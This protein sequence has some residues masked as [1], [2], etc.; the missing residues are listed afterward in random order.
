MPPA[1]TRQLGASP[2]DDGGPRS[3]PIVAILAA[4]VVAEA[5]L[6]ALRAGTALHIAGALLG[7]PQWSSSTC[8]SGA[9]PVG[10]SAA[11]C[12]LSWLSSLTLPHDHEIL[13]LPCSEPTRLVASGVPTTTIGLPLLP[14]PAG[15]QKVL[16]AAEREQ[17]KKM[18]NGH[19]APDGNARAGRPARRAWTLQ[20]QG[21]LSE[22]TSSP[23]GRCPGNRVRLP[24]LMAPSLLGDQTKSPE[25]TST[26]LFDWYRDV[27]P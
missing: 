27:S 4:A 7:L 3:L 26:V 6:A 15:R 22:T 12:S 10:A 25:T 11:R 20:A 16:C 14:I 17:V 21:L 13:G 23:Q 8:L 18:A 1:F 19:K 5:A 9:R 2:A 24:S